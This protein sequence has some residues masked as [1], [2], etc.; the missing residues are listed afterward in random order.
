MKKDVACVV[1]GV[2]DFGPAGSRAAAS[3]YLAHTAESGSVGGGS[4]AVLTT[5]P[6]SE[7]TKT[8][9]VFSPAPSEAVEV[10]PGDRASAASPQPRPAPE[11]TAQTS[12]V[13]PRSRR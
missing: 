13:R 12:A 4:V 2:F 10:S 6:P 3:L 8:S 9:M 1:V 11:R 5:S 7:A